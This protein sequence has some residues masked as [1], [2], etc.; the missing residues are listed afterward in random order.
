MG[1]AIVYSCKNR[2]RRSSLSKCP[3][4]TSSLTVVGAS[5]TQRDGLE[6]GYGPYSFGAYSPS[7]KAFRLPS[8]HCRGIV[9]NTH[10]IF[11]M[12][13]DSAPAWQS[14]HTL[15][16]T[17]AAKR[18]ILD[19]LPP[20]L[21][22]EILDV[23]V[24]SWYALLG[25]NL[26]Q[27]WHPPVYSWLKMT[28][29][30]QLWRNIALNTPRIWRHIAL[31]SNVACITEILRRSKHTSL[32]ILVD[33]NRLG[34]RVDILHTVF[35]HITRIESISGIFSH[36]IHIRVLN[37]L[38]NVRAPRLRSLLLEVD[39]NAS[40]SE[41]LSLSSLSKPTLTDLTLVCFTFPAITPLLV[42]TLRKLDLSFADHSIPMLTMLE[43]LQIMPALDNLRL[44]DTFK[45]ARSLSSSK[46]CTSPPA[47][48]CKPVTL[49]R[50]R[51]LC[52]EEEGDGSTSTSFLH[53]LILPTTC[54]I[55]LSFFKSTDTST[56]HQMLAIIAVHTRTFEITSMNIR[57]YRGW[58]YAIHCSAN[59]SRQFS[60]RIPAFR[61]SEADLS[62]GPDPNNDCLSRICSILPLTKLR[63][64]TIGDIFV[65]SVPVW[66]E[67]FGRLTYVDTLT[68]IEDTNWTLPNVLTSLIPCTPDTKL[69]VNCLKNADHPCD[70]LMFP[71]LRILRI[72]RMRP[73]MTKGPSYIYRGHEQYTITLLERLCDAL[74][75]RKMEGLPLGELILYRLHEPLDRGQLMK[76]ETAIGNEGTVKLLG[77]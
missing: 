75:R 61:H 60:L 35:S 6:D 34:E 16:A 2:A 53:H 47:H 67:A 69:P 11:V 33:S 71:K 1:N 45:H 58:K 77:H 74:I 59:S 37:E 51:S 26:Y 63:A 7:R 12:S 39:P 68:I 38:C 44:Q 13:A 42:P 28:H 49:P 64:L 25:P 15:A 23:Y 9:D 54:D 20:E 3:L 14:H 43:F 50:L 55:H 21:I 57:S 10:P 17:T 46:P 30:S 31:T 40:I 24:T 29:I 22:A 41:Q 18:T 5:R 62:L 32:E 56:F 70:Y 73:N 48:F 65:L 76:L 36:S 4:S 72:E 8:A 19:A 27:P 66:L 52:L